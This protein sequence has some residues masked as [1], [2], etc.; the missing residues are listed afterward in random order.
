M[1]TGS[2]AKTIKLHVAVRAAGSQFIF[3]NLLFSAGLQFSG[4]D[5]WPKT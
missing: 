4:G 1:I 2:S 5:Q 3:P